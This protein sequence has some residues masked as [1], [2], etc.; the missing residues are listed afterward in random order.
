MNGNYDL[1]LDNG[2]KLVMLVMFLSG[3][4]CGVFITFVYLA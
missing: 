3:C 1:E 2:L 4:V